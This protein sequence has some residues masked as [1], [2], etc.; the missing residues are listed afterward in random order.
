MVI[1]VGVVLLTAGIVS[2]QSGSPARSTAALFA[3]ALLFAGGMY[4]RTV[5]VAAG[6]SQPVPVPPGPQGPTM[7]PR[8]CNTP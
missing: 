8:P 1:A 6:R 4:G 7:P 3:L 2:L 5:L